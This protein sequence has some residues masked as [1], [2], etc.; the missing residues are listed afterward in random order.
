MALFITLGVLF[1]VR[2]LGL[3][4]IEGWHP[5]VEGRAPPVGSVPFNPFQVPLLIILVLLIYRAGVTRTCLELTE[6]NFTQTIYGLA[7]LPLWGLTPR[8]FR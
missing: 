4:S 1:F 8:A 5:T 6:T 2:S 7:Q 3:F